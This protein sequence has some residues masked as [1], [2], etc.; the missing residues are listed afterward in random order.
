[1]APTSEKPQ[2]LASLSRAN[3]S[4]D[5]LPICFEEDISERED[6]FQTNGLFFLCYSIKTKPGERTT[7]P[8]LIRGDVYNVF[9]SFR[10]DGWAEFVRKSEEHPTLR[11][12]LRFSNVCEEMFKIAEKNPGMQVPFSIDYVRYAREVG[13]DVFRT[14]DDLRKAIDYCKLKKAN[15]QLVYN[16]AM[17][18]QNLL[19]GKKED[20]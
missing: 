6:T 17:N 5:F 15:Q 2:K 9:K 7:R 11:V 16:R 3:L 14:R 12:A 4:T 1:M 13:S 20:F 19:T 18:D 10:V 8:F